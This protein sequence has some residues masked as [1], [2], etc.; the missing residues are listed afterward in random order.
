VQVRLPTVVFSSVVRSTQKAESHGG[1]YLLDL[2]TEELTQV[3]DWNDQTIDF[4]QRGGDRGLRGIAFHGDRLF[5]AAADEIMVYD[6]GFVLQQTIKNRYLRH[7]HEINVGGDKLFLGSVG[8]DSILEY[9]IAAERFTA[10]YCI[11]YSRFMRRLR[12]KSRD[13]IQLRPR[14]TL[15]VFDPES[16][17]G[18]EPGDT[19]HPSFPWWDGERL[20]VAGGGLGHIYAVQ[21]NRLRRVARIP[22]E[23]HNAHP[24]RGGLLMNHSPTHRMMF[25][26]MRGRIQRTWPVPR[27]P[28]DELEYA[29]VPQDHAYQGFCRGIAHTDHGLIVQ[30]S[31][32]A[33]INVFRWD[34]PELVKSVNVTMDVRNSV[35]G[36]EIWPFAGRPGGADTSGGAPDATAGA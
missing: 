32:P 23:S 7:C 8:Y 21:R 24:F 16:D 5:L 28:E 34:P 1:V 3:I 19:A 4:T 17:D 22:Y 15:R 14:P 25:T 2:E 11:R 35:H 33:T 12:R 36:L 27:Y 30:G 18:P 31:S 20:L 6:G 10:G 13:G 26:D 29:N 9:D